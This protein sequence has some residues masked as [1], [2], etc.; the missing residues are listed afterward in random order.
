MSRPR[1][2]GQVVDGQTRCAHYRT[3]LDI[4]AIRF[5]CCDEYYPCHRCHDEVP[6]Q[7]PAIPWP[8]ELHDA[9]ALLCGACGAQLTIAEYLG[10][11]DCP[12]C[13]ARFNPGCKL[14]AGLYFQSGT[15]PE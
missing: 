2:L 14:H 6:G 11:P 10:T 13:G 7:H 1:V 8:P 4:I 3:V 12:G 9:R 15:A 5:F